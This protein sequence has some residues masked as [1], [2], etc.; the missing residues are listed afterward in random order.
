MMIRKLFSI[1]VMALVAN[2]VVKPE[3]AYENDISNSN[4]NIRKMYDAVSLNDIYLP[5]IPLENKYAPLDD[6]TETIY[7]PMM[8]TPRDQ[9]L[10]YQGNLRKKQP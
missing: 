9:H 1:V 3:S 5:P 4:H 8:P 10:S 7:D 6:D 2:V